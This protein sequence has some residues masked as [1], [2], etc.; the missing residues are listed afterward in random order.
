MPSVSCTL[1][2]LFR[3]SDAAAATEV[4]QGGAGGGC[5]DNAGQ[6]IA[7][8][9]G[10]AKDNSPKPYTRITRITRITEII[11]NMIYDI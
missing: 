3:K 2:K 7:G 6:D 10:I 5:V 4:K 9:L 1:C 8:S 11:H